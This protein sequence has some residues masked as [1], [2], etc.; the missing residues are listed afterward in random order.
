[1]PAC[2]RVEESLAPE[3]A[4]LFDDPD[5]EEHENA[6]YQYVDDVDAG[7]TANAC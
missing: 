3:A 7:D 6:S 2:T 1:M 5:V 4:L